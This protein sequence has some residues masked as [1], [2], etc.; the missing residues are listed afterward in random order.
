LHSA[1]I[2]K[3]VDRL[4]AGL[5]ALPGVEARPSRF[6]TRGPA[7]WVSGREFCHFDRDGRID[8]RLTQAVIRAHHEL[9]QDPRV[10]LRAGSNWIRILVGSSADVR[11]VL[12]LAAEAIAVNVRSP[13]SC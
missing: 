13:G 9:E 7:F 11:F 8:L 1:A 4:V 2:P 10:G 5:R 3:L 6:G 12:D